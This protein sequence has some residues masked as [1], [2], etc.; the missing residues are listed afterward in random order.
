MAEDDTKTYYMAALK[1][2]RARGDTHTAADAPE[3]DL[4]EAFWENAYLVHRGERKP[5]PIDP[6][7]IAWFKRQG[8][9]AEA[10]INAALRDWVE[11][12]AGD[13]GEQLGTPLDRVP[14]KAKCCLS[15]PARGAWPGSLSHFVDLAIPQSLRA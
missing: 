7:L 1:A 10:R 15:Q 3:Y 2:M 13:A 5:V 6:D 14:K 9:D 4:D 12:Q 8:P 11:E